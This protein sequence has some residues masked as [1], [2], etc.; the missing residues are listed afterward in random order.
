M[1][2]IDFFF[3][4]DSLIVVVFY[5]K[6]T[7]IFFKYCIYVWINCNVFMFEEK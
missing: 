6:K 1:E 2:L 4:A 3:Q 7:I 5:L